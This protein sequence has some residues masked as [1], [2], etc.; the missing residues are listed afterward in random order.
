MYQGF[1]FYFSFQIVSF[2]F[3]YHQRHLYLICTTSWI[4]PLWLNLICKMWLP[5]N[6]LALSKGFIPSFNLM[7]YFSFPK[8]ICWVKSIFTEN[9]DEFFFSLKMWAYGANYYANKLF[10]F[11]SVE[12]VYLTNDLSTLQGPRSIKQRIAPNIFAI[13]YRSQNNHISTKLLRISVF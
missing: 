8:M 13:I 6:N 12:F 1:N 3:W 11:N 9:I 4:I 10:Y 2:S 5:D 7:L